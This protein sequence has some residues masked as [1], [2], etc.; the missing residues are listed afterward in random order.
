MTRSNQA[1]AEVAKEPTPVPSPR[2]ADR[3]AAFLSYFAAP[4]PA[5]RELDAAWEEALTLYGDEDSDAWVAALADGTH[6]LC[7]VRAPR[8]PERAA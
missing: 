2:G 4:S 1:A 5:M 8:G 6:P 3:G 7:R